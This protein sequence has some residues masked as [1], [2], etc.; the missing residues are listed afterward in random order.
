M[1]R[2]VPDAPNEHLSFTEDVRGRYEAYGWQV[3]EKTLERAGSAGGGGRR[4]PRRSTNHLLVS[5]AQG[6]GGRV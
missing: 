1:P 3:I 5:K 2:A 6:Q 4:T